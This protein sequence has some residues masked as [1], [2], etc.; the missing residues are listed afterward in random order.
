MCK[1]LF[2]IEVMF[3]EEGDTTAATEEPTISLHTLMGI[4]PR[5]RKMM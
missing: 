5:S 4:Q 1:Q 2:V 3:E